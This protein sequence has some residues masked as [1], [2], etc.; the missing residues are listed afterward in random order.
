MLVVRE[1]YSS[2]KQIQKDKNYSRSD[3]FNTIETNFN[4]YVFGSYLSATSELGAP[5]EV[6]DRCP[7]RLPELPVNDT[8]HRCIFK[9][10]HSTVQEPKTILSRVEQLVS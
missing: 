10:V 8:C 9:A 3:C 4:N 2:A 7:I 5:S 6:T 1:Q